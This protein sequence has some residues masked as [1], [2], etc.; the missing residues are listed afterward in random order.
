[1]RH[2]VTPTPLGIDF[3]VLVDRT[4][5]KGFKKKKYTTNMDGRIAIAILLMSSSVSGCITG[6]YDEPGNP[7]EP[8]TPGIETPALIE[9]CMEFT[10]MEGVG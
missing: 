4:V 6:E 7:S 3:P 10:G 8:S 9:E 1:M 2:K 5:D